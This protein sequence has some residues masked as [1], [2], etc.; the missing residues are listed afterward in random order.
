M[1]ITVYKMHTLHRYR[2]YTEHTQKRNIHHIQI[3]NLQLRCKMHKKL[4]RQNAY[5]YKIHKGYFTIVSTHEIHINS[6]Y[7][8]NAF[9]YNRH[10]RYIAHML[11]NITQYT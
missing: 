10:T 3:H 1:V 2:I 9:T 7:T 5:A 11:R 4:H 6:L 8:H